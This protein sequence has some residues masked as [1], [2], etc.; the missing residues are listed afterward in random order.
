MAEQHGRARS[1][2]TISARAVL[3]T[4]L[5][6]LLASV[7]PTLAGWETTVVRSGSMAPALSPGDVAVVRPVDAADLRAGQVL[8]VDDPDAPGGLLVHRLVAV[9]DA[10]LQVQ[11]DANPT[12]DT[13][14]VPLSAVHGVGALHLPGLG[15]PVVWAAQGRWL[16]LGGTCAVLALLLAVSLAGR[17][18]A[19]PAAHGPSRRPRHSPRAGRGAAAVAF[20]AVLALAGTLPGASVA[21]A[22]FSASTTDGVNSWAAAAASSCGTMANAAIYLPLQ[23]TAG[24]TATN[25]GTAGS[26]ANGTYSSSGVTYQA[27]GR[28]CGSDSHAVRFDGSS[29]F[30]Y[31]TAPMTNPQT[32]SVQL[33]FATTT[34]TGGKLIGFGNGVN[35][36]A[37]DKHDRQIYMTNSGKLTFGVFDGTAT[38]TTTTSTSYNDGAWHLVT[39]T[40]SA[41][42]GMRLYIDGVLST[43]RRQATVAQDYTGYWRVGYDAINEVWPGKPNSEHFNGSIA[44]VSVFTTLLSAS[45]VADQYAAAG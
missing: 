28:V 20:G 23:E 2:V 21:G 13:S 6:L 34:Y 7:A 14:L 42:T 11:G 26:S 17:S 4:V 15:L 22:V 18:A 39:A 31:T 36:A 33:W 3:G 25:R 37:S 24:P 19:D 27:N 16:P 45:D 10:G 41:D 1:A 29:G 8:L 5:L 9:T 38:Q 40:F 43:S 44:Q 32:F 30:A 35:G 12:A